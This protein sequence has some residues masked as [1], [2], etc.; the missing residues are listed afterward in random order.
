MLRILMR[1]LGKDPSAIPP[2]S[3]IRFVWTHPPVSWQV[4]VVLGALAAHLEAEK[5]YEAA[6]ETALRAW[7]DA[8]GSR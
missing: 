8:G 6:L 2:G 7:L 3:D 1:I 4:F 5:G